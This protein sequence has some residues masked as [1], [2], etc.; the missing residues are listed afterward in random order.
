M[1]QYLSHLANLAFNRLDVVQPRLS[2]R[3]ENQIEGIAPSINE[4]ESVY[5]PP[6]PRM[7]SAPQTQAA[8]APTELTN[9]PPAPELQS[10]LV[11]HAPAPVQPLFPDPKILFQERAQIESNIQPLEHL[12][13]QA[14]FASDIQTPKSP[15]PNKSP[16]ADLT[17]EHQLPAVKPASLVSPVA[18]TAKPSFKEEL[19]E[20]Y[21][22]LLQPVKL[23]AAI[24]Q[25]NYLS[26]Q[27]TEPS[28]PMVT[29]M[30]N[31]AT[32]TT[33]L[34]STQSS[35]ARQ[36]TVAHPPVK[37]PTTEPTTTTAS[38][39]PESIRIKPLEPEFIREPSAAKPSLAETPVDITPP[40]IH[41]SIGRIEIRANQTSAP[42]A[43]KS[44]QPSTMSLDDYA[45]RNGERS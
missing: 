20:T 40:S 8:Q 33:Q 24:E 13:P 4:Q 25:K 45:K 39:K 38:V 6:A 35:E 12:E 26:Q 11:N 32:K 34:D 29:N 7:P 21:L 23:A 16:L 27:A 3:F 31:F 10:E 19:V 42:A 17:N 2:S 14:S 22:P 41:V 36:N 30:A 43:A 5:E 44:R 28:S 1:S 9:T 18:A 15:Q 37:A